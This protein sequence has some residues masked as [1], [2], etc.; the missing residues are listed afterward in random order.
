MFSSINS[1]SFA[2]SPLMTMAWSSSSDAFSA[3]PCTSSMTLTWCLFSNNLARRVPMLPPLAIK[4]RLAGFSFCLINLIMVLMCLG[5]AMI[6][7]SSPSRMRV[8]PSGMIACPSRKMDTILKSLVGKRLDREAISTS[9]KTL[10]SAILT[11][12]ICTLPSAKSRTWRAPGKLISRSMYSVTIRS[13]LINTSAGRA[14]GSNRLECF[15]YSP[16][17]T[18]AIFVG[19]LKTV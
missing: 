3:R 15:R 16:L 6:K 10:C 4:M 2:A 19:V 1:S 7:T 8:S 14:R 11:A 5:A 9:T 17:R 18:R 12:T 13:G